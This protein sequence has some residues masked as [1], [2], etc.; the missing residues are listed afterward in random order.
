MADLADKLA[1]AACENIAGCCDAGLIPFDLA[2][3]TATAKAALDKSVQE[4]TQPNIRY[5]AS[6]AGACVAAYG[7]YFKGCVQ[8]NDATSTESSC[9]LVF[10]GT[11]APGEACTK[12]GECAATKD[13]SSSCQV[14]AA[15]GNAQGV[16]VAARNDSSASSPHGKLGEACVGSCEGNDNCF[17]PGAAGSAP[18]VTTWC[19]AADG[20][21]C[22]SATNTCQRLIVVGQ[23]CDFAG[24][25]T[26][27]FCASGLCS[28]KKPNGAACNGN[29]ECSVERCVFSE[30]AGASGTCGNK[31]L[32]T[33]AACSGHLSG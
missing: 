20:L 23:S 25:V 13:G 9:N 10:A 11:I 3:C 22:E 21:Q 18:S 29:R 17:G 12:S 15:S 14:E 26:G 1:T 19:F 4:E 33:T 8:Q 31:S 7:Q 24:C 27:A 30:P 28:A 5:D 2:T 16:C 32:A 6:A